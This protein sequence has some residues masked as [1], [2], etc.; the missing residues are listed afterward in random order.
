MKKIRLKMAKPLY[1]GMSILDISKILMYEFW[2]D[3][4]K[5]KYGDRAKLCYTDTDSFAIYI[6]TEDFLK[7]F[8]MMLRDG[9]TDLTMIKMI[10]DHFRQVRIKK[11]QVFLKMNQEE[12]K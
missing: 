6:K 7:V 2:Y 4:I 1:L 5:P 11:Y 3:Y 8:L 10:K 12:K 9:L